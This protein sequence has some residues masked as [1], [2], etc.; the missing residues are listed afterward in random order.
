LVTSVNKDIRPRVVL[1]EWLRLGAVELD[2]RDR[3]CLK[4]EAFIPSHG[5]DEKAYYL[6]RNVHDHV[7]AARHN[8]QDGT[9]PMLERSVYY[10]ELSPESVEKLE[11]LA[12]EEAMKV[13]QRINRRARVLQAADRKAH[14]SRHR[15]N[16]GFYF[17]RE[18]DS[19]EDA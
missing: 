16:F 6:G 13:L 1:D 15:M 3:V 19:D 12:R 10:D 7:A 14:G 17:Y 18:P 2:T 5:F 8:L 9:P 11:Q 4:T